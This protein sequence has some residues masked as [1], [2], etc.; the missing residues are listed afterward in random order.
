M[1]DQ[2]AVFANS[3]GGETV[4]TSVTD[5]QA[6]CA[7]M[8]EAMTTDEYKCVASMTDDMEGL[9]MAFKTGE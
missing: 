4:G 1:G 5:N 2:F 7:D 9:C 6:A 8:Y 3:M